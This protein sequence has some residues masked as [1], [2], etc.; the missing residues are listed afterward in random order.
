MIIH[1][2]D[3]FHGLT[4]E[5]VQEVISAM[6]TMTFSAGEVVFKAGDPADNFYVVVKGVFDL[7]MAGHREDPHIKIHLGE[8]FG[9]SSLV[10]RDTF[11]ATVECFEDGTLYKIDKE[12]L[13]HIMKMHPN[14]GVRFY[15]RLAGMVGGRVISCYEE[16][17]RLR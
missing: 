6:E 17:A 12:K 2:F 13:Y 7:F 5:V 1:H 9:W 11:S 8:A 15:R 4:D 3:L 14:I 16:M 10:G